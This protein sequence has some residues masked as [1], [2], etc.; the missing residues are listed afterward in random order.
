MSSTTPAPERAV[1]DAG[2]GESAPRA[3]GE[4]MRAL[5]AA[6]AAAEAVSTPPEPKP[7][8]AEEPGTETPRAA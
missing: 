8:Q 2:A 1:R 3:A 5:L 7:G 6:C 4:P